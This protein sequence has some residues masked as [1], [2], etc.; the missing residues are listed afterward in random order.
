MGQTISSIREL[1][2]TQSEHSEVNKQLWQSW[3]DSRVDW[4]TE[5]RDS[6]DF[7]LGNHYSQEESEALKA[8]GQGDFVIDRVYAAVE[9]LKSLLTSR[10]PKFSA[11]GR[12]DSDSRLALVWRTLLEYIWDIRWGYSVQASRS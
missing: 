5:A 1:E 6:I 7:F 3:R 8:V 11:V 9:K 4:D 2:S 12:E 10:S